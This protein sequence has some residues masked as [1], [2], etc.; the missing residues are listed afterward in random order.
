MKYYYFVFRSLTFAQKGSRALDKAGLSSS[1]CRP[2]SE[3]NSEGCAYSLK[4]NE[5]KKTAALSA[6]NRAGI[7]VGKIL[8]FNR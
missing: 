2:P 1:I 7:S 3:L 8:E 6:L 5:T 4:V